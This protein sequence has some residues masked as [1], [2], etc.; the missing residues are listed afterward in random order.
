MGNRSTALSITCA[1]A[2]KTN[3]YKEGVYVLE[4]CMIILM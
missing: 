1:Q 3:T 4:I 2:L